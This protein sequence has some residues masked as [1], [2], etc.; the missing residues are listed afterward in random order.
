ML[1]LRRCLL[2]RRI[3][4]DSFEGRLE[5]RDCGLEGEFEP[6]EGRL[7]DFGKAGLVQTSGDV[8][9]HELDTEHRDVVEAAVLGW[10]E[11]DVDVR[12]GPREERRPTPADHRA[13]RVQPA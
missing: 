6:I 10:R 12:P 11:G 8:L 1:A 4:H 7:V 5:R 2:T 13:E 9:G 3:V